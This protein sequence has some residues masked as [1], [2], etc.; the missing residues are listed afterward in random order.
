VTKF[1]NVNSVKRSRNASIGA[2]E[3]R[4]DKKNKTQSNLNAESFSSPNR[5]WHIQ[6]AAV[7]LLLSRSQAV[8]TYVAREIESESESEIESERERGR[9]RWEREM[10]EG[11]AEGEGERERERDSEGEGEGEGEGL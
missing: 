9:G 5:D 11:E 2:S 6:L 1:T 4:N 10:G 7:K 8:A 3:C